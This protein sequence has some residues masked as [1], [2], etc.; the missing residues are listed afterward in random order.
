MILA[1][2]YLYCCMVMDGVPRG[3]YELEDG[4]WEVGSVVHH[5]PPADMASRTST[6]VILTPTFQLAIV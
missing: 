3:V 6:R 2:L 4:T 1:R 5:A